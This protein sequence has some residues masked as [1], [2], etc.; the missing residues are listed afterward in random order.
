MPF[1]ECSRQPEREREYI[2]K[3]SQYNLQC[4]KV[5][6]LSLVVFAK[7]VQTSFYNERPCS[8]PAKSYMTLWKQGRYIFSCAVGSINCSE[9]RLL[10]L[11]KMFEMHILLLHNT[12][13]KCEMQSMLL[14]MCHIYSGMYVE[15]WH[16]RGQILPRVVSQGTTTKALRSFFYMVVAVVAFPLSLFSSHP[17]ETTSKIFLHSIFLTKMLNTIKQLFE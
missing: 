15:R 5:K 9:L 7:L 6:P 14:C 3:F 8:Q 12:I 2:S 17:N 4:I 11:R 13:P 10:A 16:K 1:Q